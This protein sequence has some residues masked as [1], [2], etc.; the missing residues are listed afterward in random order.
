VNDT[1]IDVNGE[2]LVLDASGAAWWPDESTL[3][4]ADIHFEKG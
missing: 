1:G 2:R 3:I 4:F